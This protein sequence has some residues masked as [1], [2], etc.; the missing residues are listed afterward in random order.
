[1]QTVMDAL[2]MATAAGHNVC[3]GGAS[4]KEPNR[5]NDRAVDWGK[6]AMPELIRGVGGVT[7]PSQGLL[8]ELAR[9]ADSGVAMQWQFMVW[10]RFDTK[11]GCGSTSVHTARQQNDC[12]RVDGRWLM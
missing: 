1:M 10:G 7:M 11:S 12:A 5:S 2:L 4:G 6:A 9:H 3:R 8:K